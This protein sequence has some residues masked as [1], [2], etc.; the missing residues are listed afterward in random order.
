MH[1]GDHARAQPQ[2]ERPAAA[3]DRT[4]RQGGDMQSLADRTEKPRFSFL[5]LMYKDMTGLERGS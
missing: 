5:L 4:G 2:P 1:G 3:R